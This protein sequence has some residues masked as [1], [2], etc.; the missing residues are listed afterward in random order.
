MSISL[1]YQICN[2]GLWE[3]FYLIDIKIGGSFYIP[4]I[5]TTKFNNLLYIQYDH[6]YSA[7]YLVQFSLM[8]QITAFLSVHITLH[9]LVV[10]HML[11]N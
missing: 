3:S 6:I 8:K 1:I 5:H 7:R 9:F 11:A 10:K 2:I 4:F